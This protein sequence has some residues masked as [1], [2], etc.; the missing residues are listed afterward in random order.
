M[1]L[2]P[3]KMSS[4]LTMCSQTG[5]CPS[6]WSEGLPAGCPPSDAADPAVNSVFRVVTSNPPTRADFI[7]VRALDPSRHFRAPSECKARALSVWATEEKCRA[8][9]LLPRFTHR[10]VARLN[11]GAGAGVLR[12]SGNRGHYSWWM[13]SAYDAPAYCSVIP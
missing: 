7:S 12:Q 2:R 8:V 10:L 5:P 9:T 4:S 11:L 1:S 3:R 6:G 13:C